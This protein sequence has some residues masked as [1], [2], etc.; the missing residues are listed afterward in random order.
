MICHDSFLFPT[1]E[2]NTTDGFILQ[3]LTTEFLSR[4]LLQEKRFSFN[5]VYT[6]TT[7]PVNVVLVVETLLIHSVKEKR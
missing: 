3:L 2:I 6:D 7:N 5:I 1:Y 4:I